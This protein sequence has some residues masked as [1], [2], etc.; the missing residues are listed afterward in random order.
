MW[1]MTE[2]LRG[3]VPSPSRGRLPTPVGWMSIRTYTGGHR[4]SAP[5]CRIR[6]DCCMRKY[7]QIL[8]IVLLV[9]ST[10]AC[11]GQARTGL[12]PGPVAIARCT[13]A[14]LARPDVGDDFTTWDSVVIDPSGRYLAGTLSIPGPHRRISFLQDLRTGHTSVIRSDGLVMAVNASGVVIAAARPAAWTY[15][16]GHVIPLPAYL[17]RNMFP[18]GINARGDI[19]GSADPDGEGDGFA[20]VIWPADHPATV[21]ALLP[22]A[23]HNS[24]AYAVTDAGMIVGDSDDR[25]FGW[26][27]LDVGHQLSTGG[28]DQLGEIIAASDRYAVGYV[29]VY[30]DG[31]MARRAVSWDLTTGQPTAYPG[32]RELW[33]ISATDIAIG[34]I[35]QPDQPDA[36]PIG[37]LI[38]HGTIERLPRLDVTVGIPGVT[39]LPSPD[40]SAVATDPHAAIPTAITADGAIVVGMSVANIGGY[41]IAGVI[42]HC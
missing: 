37:V 16:G 8:A 31:D 6:Q 14:M 40:P 21:T 12:E 1:A 11:A 13:V 28:T 20:A 17:G 3:P 32:V 34:D 35:P 30:H 19:V 7:A 41:S 10:M 42:W 38:D 18:Q 24:T 5:A 2:R 26:T 29:Y 27:G 4:Y 36:D 39:R 9:G 23:T 15:R 22:H 25:P 33:G